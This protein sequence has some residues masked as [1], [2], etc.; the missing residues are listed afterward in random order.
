M[1]ATGQDYLP[2]ADAYAPLIA[3][4]PDFLVP[5]REQARTLYSAN[6]RGAGAAAY[7]DMVTPS[8]DER[9]HADLAALRSTTP[10]PAW[11][12]ARASRQ[13]WAATC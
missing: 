13:G 1:L 2:S 6:K 7:A 10:A 5:R 12:S 3:A 4:D 8:A 11:R 9:L